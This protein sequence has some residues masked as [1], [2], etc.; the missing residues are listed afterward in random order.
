MET[1]GIGEW[2]GCVLFLFLGE[3]GRGVLGGL[4][5]GRNIAIGMQL[6]CAFSSFLFCDGR[7]LFFF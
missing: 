2:L 5:R 3:D 6:V 4:L 1:H 7:F